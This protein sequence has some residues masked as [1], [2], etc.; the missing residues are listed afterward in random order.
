MT[1]RSSTQI[2]ASLERELTDTARGQECLERLGRCLPSER[3]AF[4]QS[5]DRERRKAW[6]AWAL[7]LTPFGWDELYTKGHATPVVFRL[8]LIVI[9][10]VAGLAWWWIRIANHKYDRR[11][12]N[13][14]IAAELLG[15]SPAADSREPKPPY[16]RKPDNRQARC[17]T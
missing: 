12:R 15:L 9:F 11:E 13:A 6:I 5:W 7:V 14:T 3:Q 16:T 4:L 2:Q 8:L 17:E 10:A 1:Q